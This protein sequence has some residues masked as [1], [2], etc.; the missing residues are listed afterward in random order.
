MYKFY[1]FVFTMITERRRGSTFHYFVY[2]QQYD[3]EERATLK[4]QGDKR[5]CNLT[6]LEKKRLVTSSD[7]QRNDL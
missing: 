3:S 6:Q 1:S 4:Q 5:T 7:L 2:F